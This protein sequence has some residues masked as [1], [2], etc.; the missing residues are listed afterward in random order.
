[1]KSSFIKQFKER[2][3]YVESLSKRYEAA[4]AETDKRKV[5]A[6]DDDEEYLE[7]LRFIEV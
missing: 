6:M 1:M 5:M 3:A 2:L 4:L 7:K